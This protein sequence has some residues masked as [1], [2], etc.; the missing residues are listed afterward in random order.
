MGTS[1]RFLPEIPL[2]VPP[3]DPQE[4][5]LRAP[6]TLLL[7]IAQGVS[8]GINPKNA[9]NIPEISTM[10]SKIPSIFFF[11]FKVSLTHVPRTS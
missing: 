2:G 7:G 5:Q 10:L 3:E 4:I 9:M 11:T 6:A 1:R 8:S